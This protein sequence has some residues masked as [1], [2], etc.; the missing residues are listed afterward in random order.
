[1]RK[2]GHFII[3]MIKRIQVEGAITVQPLAFEVKGFKEYFL[4]LT[5]FNNMRNPWFVEFW[6]QNF[7]VLFSFYLPD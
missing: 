3:F 4:N 6:E 1:M 2:N 5:P 7:K